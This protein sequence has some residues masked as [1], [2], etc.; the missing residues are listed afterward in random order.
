MGI[1]MITVKCR[2]CN[3]HNIS[4]HRHY[5]TI[6]RIKDQIPTDIDPPSVQSAEGLTA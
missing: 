6:Y 4:S 2:Y 5:G 1:E 3:N